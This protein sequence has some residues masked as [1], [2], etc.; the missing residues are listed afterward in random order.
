EAALQAACAVS[1]HDQE[2]EDPEDEN[3]D[4]RWEQKQFPRHD[5]ILARLL[6][7]AVDLKADDSILPFLPAAKWS[8]GKDTDP[9]LAVLA[10]HAEGGIRFAAVEA[11]GWRLRKRK[12]P[13][14]PLVKLLKH[15]E[16]ETQF[17][18]AEGL[19]LGKREEG[20]GL[21]MASV[22]LQENYWMRGRAVT[23]L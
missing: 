21:M 8:R 4:R 3:P 1:G 7:R 16:P 17:L 15:R 14:D 6:K 5:A 20:L 18:A 2:I 12:G 19:C 23:A 22:D 13:A 9:I 10:V 11:V